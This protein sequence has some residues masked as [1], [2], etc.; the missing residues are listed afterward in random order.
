MKKNLTFV[1]AVLLAFALMLSACGSEKAPE[2]TAATVAAT[3]ATT[4]PTEAA[5]MQP[6]SL[7]GWEMTANTWSSPNGATIH[8]TATPNYYAEGQ[9]AD[10]TVRLEDA[11]V[12]TVPCQWDGSSYTAS[13]DLNAGNGYCY[14]VVLT[15][16]DGTVTEVAV[17]IPAEP[18]NE[19][20]INLEASLNSYCSIIVEESAIENG[21]LTLSVGNVQVQ[22]PV[23][24]N[25]GETIS[26][27]E[28][29]LVLSFNGEVLEQKALTLTQ[30]ETAGLFEAA[31]DGIVF[32]VPEME[33]GQL[34]ELMLN[35]TLTNDHALSA[36][37]G[38]WQ[39]SE[40]GLMTAVG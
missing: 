1:L 38:N 18:I 3:M 20:F 34:V 32:S 10:F 8:I 12:T 24:T 35:V 27:Q 30:T 29:T 17:N 39:H 31:L 2:T 16:V 5:P 33:A 15:A 37:G 28:A 6:L 19:A 7:T 36:Y 13:A 40:E 4:A 22:A 14:Y 9:T 26:C 23:I 25:E 21:Q 11:D